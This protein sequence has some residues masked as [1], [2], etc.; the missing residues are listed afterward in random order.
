MC[1][2]AD[3]DLLYKHVIG[4]VVAYLV[5]LLVPEPAECEIQ[6]LLAVGIGELIAGE[7]M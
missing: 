1:P 6:G 4:V 5:L 7:G 3:S 2:I